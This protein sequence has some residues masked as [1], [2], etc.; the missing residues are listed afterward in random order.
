MS[1]VPFP[2]PAESSGT[3]LE[4]LLTPYQVAEHL[5]ID[6]STVRRLFL[7]RSDVVKIG[8]TESRK[9]RSYV[10]LRIPVSALRRF[11]EE[12]R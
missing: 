3:P 11:L 9:K 4:P 10:T 12:R 7:D 5:Q 6:V 2:A 1:I 8:R